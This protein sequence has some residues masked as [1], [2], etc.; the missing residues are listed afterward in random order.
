MIESQPFEDILHFNESK[1]YLVE[2]INKFVEV[3]HEQLKNLQM[4]GFVQE[5]TD[6]IQIFFTNLESIAECIECIKDQGELNDLFYRIDEY[7]EKYSLTF[8]ELRSLYSLE[9]SY[10]ANELIQNPIS[11]D[12]VERLNRDI[13]Q[14]RDVLDNLVQLT[15]HTYFVLA[16]K[17]Q[18][19]QRV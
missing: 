17:N 15:A 1:D 8:S 3:K 5:D 13:K 18:G 10:R 14:K 7:F 2:K 11:A 16:S 6:L 19:A 4:A 12:K 9:A